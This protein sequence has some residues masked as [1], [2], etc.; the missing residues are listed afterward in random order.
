M[1]DHTCIAR[2]TEQ[3]SYGDE[4]RICQYHTNVDQDVE[5]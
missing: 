3:C 1:K 5:H 4:N 2:N